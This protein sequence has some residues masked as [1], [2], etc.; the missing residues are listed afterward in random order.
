MEWPSAAPGPCDDLLPH[1]RHGNSR[2][3]PRQRRRVW[4][5]LPD[6][7]PTRPHRGGGPPGVDERAGGCGRR[8]VRSA[9]LGFT[10]TS[11]PPRRARMSRERCSSLWP[12]RDDGLQ[13]RRRRRESD[14]AAPSPNPNAASR[15]LVDGFDTVFTADGTEI[16]RTPIAARNANAYAEP[17]VSSAPLRV[18][19][20]A[21]D[22]RRTAPHPRS[23]GVH[24]ALQPSPAAPQPRPSTA[25]RECRGSPAASASSA[26]PSPRPVRRADPRIRARRSVTTEYLRPG[27]TRGTRYWTPSLSCR[28][29]LISASMGSGS[30][31]SGLVCSRDR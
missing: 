12:G 13:G 17:W 25:V 19:G 3:P 27:P 8:D 5:G 30:A 4:A 9:G 6:R 15:A 1:H 16:I 14:R 11:A 29:I 26:H 20:L 31:R 7:D 28:M 2:C 22:P 18:P 10:P 24:R 21:P 23:R